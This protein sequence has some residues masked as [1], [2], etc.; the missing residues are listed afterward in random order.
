MTTPP[1][2]IPIVFIHGFTGSSEDWLPI[3]NE[4]EGICDPLTIDLVGHGSNEQPDRLS[5]YTIDEQ[6][7]RIKKYVDNSFHN[8]FMLAGYS[9]GGRIA[10]HWALKYPERLY[11][12]IL[13]STTAGIEDESERHQRIEGDEELAQ[14]IESNN[15]EVFVDKWMNLPLFATQ[16]RM[17]E[18]IRNEIRSR[19][20]KN[21]K[22]GLT[23][24]LRAAGTGRMQPVWN[25]L[26]QLSVPVLLIT[27]SLDYKFTE[28]NKRMA[29]A[30]PKCKHKIINDA[31]HNTHLEKPK[32]YCQVVKE[33]I[34]YEMEKSKGLF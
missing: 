5:D 11:G 9:M 26:A 25:R 20:L 13:E 2:K 8:K 29:S 6:I 7:D 12:L 4:L 32:Q 22:I 33:F 28:I 23:N 27:G 24:T 15:M 3:V 21:S 18:K 34:A 31:G 19:K 1:T 17:P 14:F 30:I 16:S 10:L